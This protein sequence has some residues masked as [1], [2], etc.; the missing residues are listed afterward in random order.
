LKSEQHPGSE[1]LFTEQD[2]RVVRPRQPELREPHERLIEDE[3]R[4]DQRR[5]QQF[6]SR[7]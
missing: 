4:G 6:D 1:Q 5:K 7:H 2:S 3:L